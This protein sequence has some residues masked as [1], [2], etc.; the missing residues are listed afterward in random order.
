M[1]MEI[2]L[3][4]LKSNKEFANKVAELFGQINK[5]NNTFEQACYKVFGITTSQADA[6][7]K[8]SPK[9]ALRMNELSE[10]AGL[11]TST[12]TRMVDQLIEKGFVLRQ[13]D[14]KDRR[15]VRVGLTPQGKKLRKELSDALE[16]Y[17][18][19]S[20]DDISEPEREIIVQVLE[21]LKNAVDKGLENCCNKYCNQGLNNYKREG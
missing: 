2:E 3:N 21:R 4:G 10:A 15:I 14:D 9:E 18:M 17:Y 19:E 5:N 11:D 16:S 20:L 7:L 1:M 6:L 8:L 13:A 12:M